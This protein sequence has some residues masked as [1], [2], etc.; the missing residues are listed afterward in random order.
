MT[1]THEPHL[2]WQNDFDFEPCDEINHIE[3]EPL[4]TRAAGFAGKV[5]DAPGC[6][7]MVANGLSQQLIHEVNLMNPGVLVSFDELNVK[8]GNAAYAFLQPQAKEALKK[9]IRDR[10]G[11]TLSINS[12]YRTI[13]QQLLLYGWREGRG[14][15]PYGLVAAPGRSNHQGGLA[16]DINDH[17]G[18]RP[19]LE[20]YGWQWFGNRDKPHF[21]YRGSGLKDIRS[22][23]IEAFQR[24]WNQ[25]NPNDKIDEDGKY[26]NQTASR[27]NQTSVKGFKIAPWDKV[28]R[29]LR[30]SQPITEGSD[31]IRL[32]V[33]LKDEGFDIFPDGL[34]GKQTEAIVKEFQSRKGLTPDGIVGS[35]T[36]DVLFA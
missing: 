31:V 30:F 26:G 12:G 29:I 8:L 32:Q 11:V 4:S 28:P 22:D 13:V 36:R 23:A 19:H 16:I 7:T 6:S 34:F 3:E 15:C 25:N 24:L 2:D 10:P 14:G 18:W 5:E 9:A 1:H 33:A 17:L 35:A 27:I 20:R 21:T